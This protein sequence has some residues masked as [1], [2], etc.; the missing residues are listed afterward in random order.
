MRFFFP[1]MLVHEKIRS[2]ITQME[3]QDTINLNPMMWGPC[4]ESRLRASDPLVRSLSRLGVSCTCSF[5]RVVLA[6]GGDGRYSSSIDL[7]IAARPWRAD[8]L[9]AYV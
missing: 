9:Y 8:P 3:P 6:L 1:F 4:I 2:P 7:N 5:D